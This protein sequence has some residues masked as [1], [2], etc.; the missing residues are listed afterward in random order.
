MGQP[1]RD[2]PWLVTGMSR[3]SGEIEASSSFGINRR[4]LL[5]LRLRPTAGPSRLMMLRAAESLFRDP[6]SVPS[7]R[8]HEFRA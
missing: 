7:S 1:R 3:G 4:D 2:K 8:Y 5:R 6:T